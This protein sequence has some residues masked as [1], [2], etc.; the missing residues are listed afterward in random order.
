MISEGESG[1]VCP[2][3]DKNCFIRRIQ[4]IMEIRGLKERLSVNSK[5][6][7]GEKITVAKE[8]YLLKYKQSMEECLK[9]V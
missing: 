6:F 4:E 8:E 2:V 7:L 3:N 9:R 5:I 1:F